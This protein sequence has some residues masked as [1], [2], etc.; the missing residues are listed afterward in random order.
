MDP[1][2]RELAR[3]LENS[4]IQASSNAE[5]FAQESILVVRTKGSGIK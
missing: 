2:F 1:Q 3:V 4:A 5:T